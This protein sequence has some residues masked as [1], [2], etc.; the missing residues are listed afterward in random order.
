MKRRDFAF[1]LPRERIARFPADRREESRLMVV[2]RSN[3]KIHHSRFSRLEAWLD[4]S[5]FM[6]INN[7]LSL[8]HI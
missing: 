5:D 6:V 8:I 4:P 2:D 1:H 3:G 7:T